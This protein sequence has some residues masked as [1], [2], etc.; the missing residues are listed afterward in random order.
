MMSNLQQ[1]KDMSK[2]LKVPPGNDPEARKLRAFADLLDR[3][4]AL[5]PEKRIEV[6]AALHHPFITGKW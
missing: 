1:T 4:L 6:S 5:D 2:L 3:M